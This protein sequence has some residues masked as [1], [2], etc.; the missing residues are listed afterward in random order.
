MQR[1]PEQHFSVAVL[2]NSS[3]IDAGDLANQVTEIY[4]GDLLAPEQ[5]SAS[6]EELAAEQTLISKFDLAHWAPYSGRFYSREV[7]NALTI[8]VVTG[9]IR[10]T[11]IDNLSHGRLIPTGRDTFHHAEIGFDLVF[12]R[13]ENQVIT[14]LVYNGP[15]VSGLRFVRQP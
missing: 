6:V 8:F 15:R 4:L 12:E 3:A 14:A 13:D 2:C 1:F 10:I 7:E 11:G 9:G 5:V